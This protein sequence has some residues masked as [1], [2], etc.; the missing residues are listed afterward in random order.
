MT[1][2]PHVAPHRPSTR[3]SRKVE[4]TINLTRNVSGGQCHPLK[5]LVNL[6]TIFPSLSPLIVIQERPLYICPTSPS[7]ISPSRCLT[8]HQ[9]PHHAALQLTHNPITLRPRQRRRPSLR[10]S[11][12]SKAL[13][14]AAHILAPTCPR[15]TTRSCSQLPR[16]RHD[17]VS[18]P[19]P[20]RTKKRISSPP[21]FPSQSHIS[22]SRRLQRSYLSLQ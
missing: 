7:P 20:F 5:E 8:I 9:Q 4:A 18:S 15:Q 11:N 22:R 14:P 17:V 19:F 12:P 16:M 13:I 10:R 1:L 6:A 21:F 3:P 2:I